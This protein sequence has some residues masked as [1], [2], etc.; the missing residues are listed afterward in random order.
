MP[1]PP[2][3]SGPHHPHHPPR[4]EDEKPISPPLPS[5]PYHKPAKE[6]KGKSLL[7]AVIFGTLFTI[8]VGFTLFLFNISINV[9]LPVLAPIWVGSAT[10]IY[11][12]NSKG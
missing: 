9:I 3:P 8:I 1:T 7:M 6:R 11:S 5:L 10:L 2:P 4:P 12:V